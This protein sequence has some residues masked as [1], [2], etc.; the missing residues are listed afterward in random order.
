MNSDVTQ[1]A[2]QVNS[3][4]DFLLITSGI[5]CAILIFGMIYF[6]VKYKRK[7]NNDKTPYISHNSFLEF[8][9]S[10]IPLVIFMIVFAWG[11]IIYHE[12]RKFPKD[13]LEVHVTAKQWQ[14]DFT[15]KSGK[16]SANEFYVPVNKPVKLIMT[17][18]DVIHSFYIP[19]MKIKQD[20]VPGRYSALGFKAE[21]L[22]EFYVFCT[23]FCGT[24]HSA[25]MAK[26]K[27]VSQADY[28][29]WLQETDEGLSM[30][31]LGAK[32]YNEKGCVACHSLDGSKRVGP[33][34]K[35]LFGM[36]DH[37]M[38][39]GEKLIADENYIRTSILN[40]QDKIVKGYGPRSAMPA[41]QGQ[42][43]E[44]EVAALIEY[45]KELK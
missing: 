41:Y 35:G 33:S 34:W 14:W 11:W 43:N 4:Y 31:Q 37:E 23:E 7:T 26:L 40:S 15:Y 24:A 19:S 5:A 28:E 12:M 10:F 6:A 30:A 38:E 8:L 39:G 36:K 9:W 17:S 18:M 2:Q 22:G 42:L 45:I 32:Y 1:I 25:M 27:V 13:S 3:L 21:K 29:K 20:V 16:T 44:K